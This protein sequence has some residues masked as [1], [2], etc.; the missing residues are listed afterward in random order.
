MKLMGAVVAAA[1]GAVAITPASADGY[2]KHFK[3]STAR[4]ADGVDWTGVY[5]GIHT[6]GV[7]GKTTFYRQA[8]SNRN[9]PLLKSDSMLPR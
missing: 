1:V 2:D 6:G 9:V 4:H 5:A 8:G 3:Y 7:S